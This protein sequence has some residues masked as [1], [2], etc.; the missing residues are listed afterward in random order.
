MMLAVN[1]IPVVAIELKN[2]LTGQSVDNAKRQWMFDRDPKEPAFRL[3]HRI[4]V[5]SLIHI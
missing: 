1:G 2:Q 5:L 3:N 4:L